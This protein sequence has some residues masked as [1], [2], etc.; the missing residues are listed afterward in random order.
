MAKKPLPTPE[1]LRQLLR[2]EPETG[3]LFWRERTPEMFVDG[4]NGTAAGRC[5]QWNA[6]YAN[7][8]AFTAPMKTGYLSGRAFGA[9][10][11]A[12]RVAWAI[13]EGCWPTGQIDHVNGVRS[14]NRRSN[15]RDVSL[16][17]NM[18]NVKR[19]VDNSSGQTGVD[20][21]KT[22]NLW[23]A[24]AGAGTI[25]YFKTRPEAV[26]A[27]KADEKAIGFHPN[28]GRSVG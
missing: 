10:H 12:H 25:G 9:T 23:R 26:A 5:A 13:F 22:L 16:E 19:R 28:H 21:H 14:D 15:M 8:P 2:Y 20:F 11:Y 7:R 1:Q 17:E 18:R 27:R 3:K 24:R 6:R 4:N